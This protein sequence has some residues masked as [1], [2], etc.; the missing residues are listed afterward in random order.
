M[1][2]KKVFIAAD[3]FVAFIDRAHPNHVHTSAFFRYFAQEH[4][5]LYTTVVSIND[6]YNTIYNTISPSLARDF[7]RAMALSTVN[8]MYPENA[9]MKTA[10][11]TVEQSNSVDL[12]FSK[13]LT[14]VICNKRSIPQ[15][16]TF[17]YLP[18][19]FGIQVFYLPV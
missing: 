11:K 10:I 17:E 3:G 1:V 12:T 8:V 9:D 18:S 6:A 7:L 13:A 4:F 14:A 2:S 15:V 16:C 5:Q 19:L